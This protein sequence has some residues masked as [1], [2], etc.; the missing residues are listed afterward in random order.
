MNVVIIN[1]DGSIE[2]RKMDIKYINSLLQYDNLIITDIGFLGD[3]KLHIKSISHKNNSPANVHAKNLLPI[4]T[5]LFGDVMIFGDIDKKIKSVTFD[6]LASH[7]ISQVKIEEPGHMRLTYRSNPHLYFQEEKYL[8]FQEE[9]Y[10]YSDMDDD[11][12]Y[13]DYH[14]SG[15]DSC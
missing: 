11:E 15:Y 7:L 3:E 8:Y 14:E 6:L 4:K 12:H 5:D 1:L 2:D 10:L 13:W 9:K